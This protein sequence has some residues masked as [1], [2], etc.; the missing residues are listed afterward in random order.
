MKTT[1]TDWQ[2]EIW[3]SAAFLVLALT[4]ALAGCE[5][6]RKLLDVETPGPDIEIREND[7]LE[8]EIEPPE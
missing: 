5:R 2:A 6:E 7:G 8:I 3:G 4:L 1:S